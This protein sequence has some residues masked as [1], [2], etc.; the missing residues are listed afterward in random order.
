MTRISLRPASRSD[1]GYGFADAIVGLFTLT[2]GLILIA[3]LFAH[4]LT[5]VERHESVL[6]RQ[7]EER[8]EHFE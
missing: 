4:A 3:S 6:R 7:L 5:A 8:S 2:V 1:G